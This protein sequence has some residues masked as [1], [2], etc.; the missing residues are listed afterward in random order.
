[1]TFTT[2]TNFPSTVGLPQ[3]VSAAVANF[4]GLSVD[5]Q[6]GLLWLLYQNLGC[7]LT[8]VTPGAARI[9]LTQGLLHRIKQMSH[10]EQ[11]GAIRDLLAGADTAI[12]RQ[13]GTFVPNTKLAFWYQLFEWMYTGEVV[14][15]PATYK[16][17]PVAEKVLKQIVSLDYSEQIMVVRQVVV[18]MG[19][20]LLSA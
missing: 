11:L 13:Y 8:P 15:A 2:D 4:R 1:M 20:E 19:V 9:F 10:T 6:L 12:A 18:E 17:S 5:D 3:A 14:P 16:L 7:S